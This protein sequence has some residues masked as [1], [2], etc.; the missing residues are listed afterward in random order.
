[1]P[2][3]QLKKI[4]NRI[5]FPAIIPSPYSGLQPP[6]IFLS[7][8]FF[9]PPQSC[10]THVGAVQTQLLNQI[11]LLAMPAWGMS[12]FSEMMALPLHVGIF[13]HWL[14]S[15]PHHIIICVSAC[16]LNTLLLVNFWHMY[17][18]SKGA[19]LKLT[20]ESHGP[21]V[22]SQRGGQRYWSRI[23]FTLPQLSFQN[24]G[25]IE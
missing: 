4:N 12:L 8:F 7:L 9:C 13:G 14:C 11:A 25:V 23:P 6:Y 15:I 20:G 3:L 22:S 17:T 18:S 1:M 16:S 21:F 2:L 19:R 24:G 5:F 10:H